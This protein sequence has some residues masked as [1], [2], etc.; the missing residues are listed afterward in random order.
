MTKSNSLICFFNLRKNILKQDE[1]KNT[2]VNHISSNKRR[3]SN[4]TAQ[5]MKFSI[6]DFLSNCNQ[7]RRIFNGKFHF[8]CSVSAAP[9]TLR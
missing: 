7:I 2:M 3:I 5:K 4:N 1:T 8:L 6:K 9:L